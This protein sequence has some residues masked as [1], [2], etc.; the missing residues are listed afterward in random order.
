MPV[1]QARMAVY[2]EHQD[3]TKNFMTPN[4]SETPTSG[5]CTARSLRYRPSCR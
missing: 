5:A 4:A 1:Q 2:F 3:I